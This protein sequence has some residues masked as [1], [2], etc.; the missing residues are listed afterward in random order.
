MY[1]MRAIKMLNK[2]KSLD[3][4]QGISWLARCRWNGIRHVLFFSSFYYS[5]LDD[6]DT[7]KIYCMNERKNVRDLHQPG[8]IGVVLSWR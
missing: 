6:A 4:V 2:H 8:G 7:V 3:T 1:E 5:S